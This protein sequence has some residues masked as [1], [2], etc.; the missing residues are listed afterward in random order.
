MRNTDYRLPRST[1]ESQGISSTALLSFL[2]TVERDK[3]E[4]HSLMVVRHGHVVAEGWWD[5][6]KADLPHMLFS[7]SKS[8]TSTAVGLAVQEGLLSVD[9][10]VVSFFPEETP[11][12]PPANL[13]EMR[14]RHLLCMGTGH[15]EDT[16]ERITKQEDKNWVKGFLTTTVEHP[17]GTHFVYNSGAS[18]ML[19]AIIQKVTGQKLLDYLKP[20]LFGPLGI[21]G[22]TWAMCPEGI[23]TGGWGLSLCTE[24]IAKFGQLYLQNGQWR[25]KRILSEAWVDEAT[26]SQISNGEG[27][28]NDWQHGYGYQFWRCQR[29]DV[30][31]GDGAF[32]QYCIVMPEQD[33]VIAI[34][35]AVGNMQAVLNIVWERLLPAME[36]SSLPLD[37][38]TASTLARHLNE[39]AIEPPLLEAGSPL[40]AG[41]AGK[42]YEFEKNKAGITSLVFHFREGAVDITIENDGGVHLIS[43]GVNDWIEGT[44]RV[45]QDLEFSR[46]AASAAW[47]E[48]DTLVLTI[49]FPETPFC[50]TYACMFTDDVLRLELSQNVGFGPDEHPVLIGKAR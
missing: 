40:S 16:M 21:E 33:V 20:R 11:A 41:V 22:A 44:T 45:I 37:D 31:R 9:D 29:R 36:E 26:S 4:L 12:N 25:G 39:V 6:Y 10:P 50:Q 18:Y 8:F 15:A 5:P 23:N 3:L 30:Y 32:G 42:R 19:S 49:R 43:C 17:P 14:V 46:V 48:P 35:S 2:D 28:D 47:R 34:T 27:G 24:D 38:E 1:P 13:A 7:L